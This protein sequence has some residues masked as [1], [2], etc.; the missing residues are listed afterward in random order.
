MHGMTFPL[1]VINLLKGQQSLRYE[2]MK[3][4]FQPTLVNGPLGDPALFIDFLFERRALLFDLGDIGDLP[5]RKILRL[6]HLFISHTHMDHFIGF[7]HMVRIFLGREK[8]LHL[9]GPPGFLDQVW[10]RLA[11]YT[12]NLVE[13]FPTDFTIRAMEIYPDGKA[14]AADFHCRKAF[15]SE[16]DEVLTITDGVLLDEENFRVRSI[17]LDHKIPCLAYT[18]EE[19]RH[20]NIMRNHLDEMG[21]KVGPWLAELKKA[22]LREEPEETQFRIWWRESG[23]VVE[24]WMPLGVL[25][26]RILN[27]V[28]GQK[29][30]YVTDAVCSSQNA[31]KIIALAR[32]ADYLFIEAS[33][34]QEEAERAA[35]KYHLTAGQ[36][37]ALARRAKAVRVIPFHFSPK[38]AGME[39]RLEREVE[40][41][42][43]NGRPDV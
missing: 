16:G 41:A 6:S 2:P 4:Q 32:D 28:P 33:F 42:R 43:I 30:T 1:A 24:R 27:V 26:S 18:L 14:L 29:I 8:K 9:F 23:G 5:P 15:H 7:D 21:L 34:L 31:E 39:E 3:P 20:V 40:E 10:H 38:Y 13:N 35:L 11:A 25:Q 36:A 37:G 19:K 12:W 22:V 17:F